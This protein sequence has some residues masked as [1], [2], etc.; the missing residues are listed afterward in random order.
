MA[1]EVPLVRPN[2]PS[3]VSRLTSRLCRTRQTTYVHIWVNTPTLTLI[4]TLRGYASISRR[5]SLENRRPTSFPRESETDESPSRTGDR[6]VSLENRRPPSFPRERETYE[7]SS[8]IGDRRV[9]LKSG[10]LTDPPRE[11]ESDESLSRRGGPR[12]SHEN[13][14]PT[15]LPRGRETE[16]SFS[17]MGKRRALPFSRS[18]IA[19]QRQNPA[20]QSSYIATDRRQLC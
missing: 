5:V 13:Q 18:I 3:A 10:R 2:L 14:R 8:R 7:S 12:V 17:R 9:S 15:D 1:S 11:R 4:P 20:V 16:K 6:R 19:W